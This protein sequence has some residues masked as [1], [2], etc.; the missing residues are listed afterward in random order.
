MLRRI[1]ILC[2]RYYTPHT[3]DTRTDVCQKC[4]KELGDVKSALAERTLK[5]LHDKFKKE[6]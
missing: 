6:Q 2:D 3:D 1:C 5:G 4:C